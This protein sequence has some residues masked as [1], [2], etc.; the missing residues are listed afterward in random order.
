[1]FGLQVVSIWIKH[2]SGTEFGALVR[3]QAWEALI[4]TSAHQSGTVEL[5]DGL[6]WERKLQVN[7]ATRQCHWLRL[8]DQEKSIVGGCGL[9]RNL[10]LR[11]GT[12]AV[13]HSPGLGGRVIR[14]CELKEEVST[15][16]RGVKLV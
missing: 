13:T 4:D 10:C 14:G 5:I 12:S 1:M 6:R 15:S 7:A 8:L 2:V 9:A 16:R 11:A 3:A